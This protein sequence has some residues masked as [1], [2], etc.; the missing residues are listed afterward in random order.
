MWGR[1][2]SAWSS[3]RPVEPVQASSPTARRPLSTAFPARGVDRRRRPD[4]LVVVRRQPPD[5]LLLQTVS[6]RLARLREEPAPPPRDPDVD[7]DVDA[8]VAARRQ[9]GPPSTAPREELDE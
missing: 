2:P 8:A 7:L 6:A 3:R 5:P 4:A 9:A 1:A